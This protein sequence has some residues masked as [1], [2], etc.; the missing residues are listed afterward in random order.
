MSSRA[1]ARMRAHVSVTYAHPHAHSVGVRT[2][3]PLAVFT[4][5]LTYTPVR[6]LSV[7]RLIAMEVLTAWMLSTFTYALAYDYMRALSL[8]CFQ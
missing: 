8:A 4:H 6:A 3:W 1:D 7:S 2:A 5:A